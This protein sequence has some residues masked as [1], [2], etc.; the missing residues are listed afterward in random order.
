[1][2]GSSV[3]LNWFTG[4]IVPPP[5]SSIEKHDRKLYF[6]YGGD[7]YA[8]F[9]YVVEQWGNPW[10]T[11]YAYP[12]DIPTET[13]FK[14]FPPAIK[15]K[16]NK[17]KTSVVHDHTDVEGEQFI[18]DFI[19]SEAQKNDYVLLKLDKGSPQS[20]EQLIQ[21]I[22]ENDD[23]HVD[24]IVWQHNLDRNYLLKP[25]FDT[26]EAQPLSDQSFNES[27]MIFSRLRQKGIRAH[28][29]V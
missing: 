23:V 16:V 25:I 26:T 7:K 9:Q 18:P 29:W 2:E 28:A 8:R 3:K 17:L 1:L 21:Y 15:E 6:E 19:N 27:Y 12:A 14:H 13:F 24:E 20:K 4:Y 11:I 22:L 10:D 5:A